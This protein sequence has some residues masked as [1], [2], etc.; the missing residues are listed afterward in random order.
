MARFQISHNDLIRMKGEA[1]RL[2]TR[3]KN[4]LEKADSVVERVVRTVE[5]GAS[6]FGFGV[7]Q[8]KYG[9]VEVVGIPLELAAGAGLHLLAFAGIGGHMSDHLHHFGDGALAC[10]AATTGRGVGVE[11]RKKA[12]QEN[13]AG[14]GELSAPKE[15]LFGASSRGTRISDE[16]M[17]RVI[18]A[19]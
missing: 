8:G 17:A 4:A 1:E 14:K 16:E 3:A 15:R 7:V 12:A 11:W 10:Y 2:K 6:A 13:G 5:V 19:T 18:D 9:G